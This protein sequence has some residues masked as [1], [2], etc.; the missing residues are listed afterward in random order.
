MTFEEIVRAPSIGER[1]D[2]ADPRLADIR[3]RRI[4]GFPRHLVFHRPA[5]ETDDIVRGLHG[6][7]DVGRILDRLAEA[8]D[9][10]RA[11]EPPPAP[12]D[13]R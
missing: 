11:H 5:G 1:H 7:R 12:V 6:A 13:P 8:E 9:Q 3:V 2:S 4:G 10:D